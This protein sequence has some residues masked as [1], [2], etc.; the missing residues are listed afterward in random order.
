MLFLVKSNPEFSSELLQEAKATLALP[1][2]L[3]AGK[4]K[5]YLRVVSIG[6]LGFDCRSYCG[7]SHRIEGSYVNKEKGL[8]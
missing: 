5:I 6:Q 4:K 1:L 3:L 2:I 7:C 8:Y